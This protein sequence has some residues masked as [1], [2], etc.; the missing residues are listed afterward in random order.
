MIFGFH[1]HSKWLSLKLDS[2]QVI[3]YSFTNQLI[4]SKA[5]ASL[6][7][8]QSAYASTRPSTSNSDFALVPKCSI[9]VDTC[10]WLPFISFWK[11]TTLTKQRSND[12]TSKHSSDSIPKMIFSLFEFVY[13]QSC[14]MNVVQAFQATK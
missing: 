7:I 11:F 4:P 1:F 13:E 14:S 12:K 3:R 2:K 5:T 8:Q 10:A 6:H 9:D